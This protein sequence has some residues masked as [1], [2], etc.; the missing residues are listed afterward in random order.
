M[1]P[2]LAGGFLTTAAPGKSRT[3]V[4]TL[5]RRSSLEAAEVGEGRWARKSARLPRLVRQCLVTWGEDLGFYPKSTGKL[6]ESF[7]QRSN[8]S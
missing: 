6:L 3:K 4:L 1:S 5:E 7:K 8:K 2:A